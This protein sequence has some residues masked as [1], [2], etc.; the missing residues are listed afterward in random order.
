MLLAKANNVGVES[1]LIPYEVSSLKTMGRSG[2][3]RCA[4]RCAPSGGEVEGPQNL[5]SKRGS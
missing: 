1:F 2:R 5:V 4:W 3:A